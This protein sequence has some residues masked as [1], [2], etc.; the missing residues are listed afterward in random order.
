MDFDKWP[1][2]DKDRVLR[3]LANGGYRSPRYR[4]FYVSTPKVACTTMKWWFAALEG[5]TRRLRAITESAESDPDLIIHGY[6]FQAVAPEVTGLPADVLESILGSGDYFRFG[7][8][9]NPYKRIFSAWQSKMLLQEPLQITPYLDMEFLRHPI[10]TRAQVAAAF[11]AFLEHL[12]SAEAPNFWD[13][14]WTPQ[15]D[16][17]RPDLID[18]SKI[19][20]L[21]NPDEI[22]A[23]LNAWTG[24][25]LVSPFIGKRRNESLIP[26]ATEFITDRSAALIAQIYAR[27]FE[28]F[29][30]DLKL[31]AGAITLRTYS[32]RWRS[33]R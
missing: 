29:G 12:A 19:I 7:L 17:L 27:D 26:Y 6:N 11:E 24:E 14:H 18:Y 2:A 25:H 22:E 15:A 30:Y 31:P 10:E 3:Y 28:L 5:K 8:V 1:A 20:Q 4:I 23:Q 32:S 33:R 13:L 21:E 16:L 9:R